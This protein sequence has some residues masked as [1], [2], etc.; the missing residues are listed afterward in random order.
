MK[1]VCERCHTRYSIADDKVRQKIL[2]I[3]C[4]TC[5]NVITVRD[6][7][8]VATVGFGQVPHSVPPPPP[9]KGPAA[10]REWFVA[11]NGEQ[12]GPMS[13]SDLARRVLHCKP[14]DEVYV[15]KDGQDG[16]KP[17]EEV[18]VIQQE[19]NTLKLRPS[20]P[21]PRLPAPPPGRAPGAG[22]PSGP[23]RS[24]KPMPAAFAGSSRAA[25]GMSSGSGPATARAPEAEA[26]ADEEHTQIQP[27]DAGVLGAEMLAKSSAPGSVLPFT[28]PSNHRDAAPAAAPAALDGLFSDL[29]PAPMAEPG[30]P[31]AAAP[32]VGT[33]GFS[34]LAGRKPTTLKFIA[35]GG[36]ML[37]LVGAIV[38][39]LMSRPAQQPPVVPTP[40]PVAKSSP[41]PEEQ[42]KPV[43]EQDQPSRSVPA[44]VVREVTR[45]AGKGAGKAARPTAP[46]VQSLEPAPLSPDQL[47][48][49]HAVA[50]GERRVP[51][52]RSNHP[53]AAAKGGPTD[54]AIGAVVKK[55]ENQLALKTCYERALKRDDRLRS[56][57][58]DV[59][60]SVG[61][62]GIVKTVSLAAPPEFVTVES[63]IKN[64]VRHWSF[65]ANSEEYQID[66]PIL[67]QGNQ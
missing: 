2:K 61:M 13:K 47:A 3:R 62:S 28:S 14:E 34:A 32:G 48:K 35:A 53:A 49:P 24:T 45:R 29:T 67:L 40:V 26:F 66:F 5:E 25:A 36:V 56:A 57:R 22:K 52:F 50:A 30:A 31:A 54:G 58:I 20:A 43:I 23:V 11:I 15:W 55:R 27:F 65:P 51:E 4:K 18:P 63:C 46:P 17:P 19:I 9:G 44:P 39:V 38:W 64:A 12:S 1:F 6:S 33:A 59:S 8:P 60:A 42:P 7:G 16:W 41:P 21:V 37:T 10:A